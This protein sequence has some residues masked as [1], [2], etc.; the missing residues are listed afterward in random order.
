[1]FAQVTLSDRRNRGRGRRTG[2]DRAFRAVAGR[3]VRQARVHRGRLL[4]DDVRRMPVA[5]HHRANHAADVLVRPDAQQD[6]LRSSSPLRAQIYRWNGEREG[7]GGRRVAGK[8]RKK[9]SCHC[10]STLQSYI[11][12]K[13]H[14][15]SFTSAILGR[16]SRDN[17]IASGIANARAR[18]LTTLLDCG[19]FSRVYLLRDEGGLTLPEISSTVA[20]FARTS[21]LFAGFS[22]STRL[23]IFQSRFRSHRVCRFS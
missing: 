8:K 3:V 14:R 9:N 19:F 17:G 5:E 10:E 22:P 12:A 1:M 2:T 20:S 13:A 16:Y 4:L 6:P 21:S 18:S 7:G 15:Y 23:C 11:I